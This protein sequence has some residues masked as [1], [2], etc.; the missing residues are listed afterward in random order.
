[1]L[2]WTAIWALLKLIVIIGHLPA[3]WHQFGYILRQNETLRA[4]EYR[5]IEIKC[6]HEDIKWPRF[7]ITPLWAELVLH[8][9]Q[10]WLFKCFSTTCSSTFNSFST[11]IPS[12][13]KSLVGDK[14]FPESKKYPEK[15]E[16]SLESHLHPHI[17]QHP[18]WFHTACI[19]HR[20]YR[21]EPCVG[22]YN[23]IQ[24]EQW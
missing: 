6:D 12:L 19:S 9:L 2:D 15:H 7:L 20:L 24:L 18:P 21:L 22:V 8:P 4:L 10:W 3:I 1:M 13:R 14:E 11:F 5:Q 23:S 17:T 16:T